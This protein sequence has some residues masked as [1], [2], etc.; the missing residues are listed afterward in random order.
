MRPQ[1]YKMSGRKGSVL[2]LVVLVVLISFIIGTG[3]L[4]L[5]TQSR[6]ASLH[7]TQD[8]MARSAADAG[9]EH[10]IQQIN[11]AVNNHT[12]SSKEKIKAKDNPLSS[13]SAYTVEG[14]YDIATEQ[15]DLV[16]VGTN[17][18]RVRTVHATI[19]LKGLFEYAILL[20]ETL[21]LKAGTTIDGYHSDD[22][23]VKDVGL[24]IATISTDPDQVILNMGATVNGEVLAG[25]GGD[26]DTVIKDL[27]ATTSGKFNLVEEPPFPQITAPLLTPMGSAISVAGTTSVITPADSGKYTDIRVEQIS[28]SEKVKGKTYTYTDYGTLEV[29]GG[30]VVLHVTGDIWI[31]QGCEILVKKDSSLTLYIDGNIV[32]GNGGGF[33]Y[34]GSPN[35]PSHVQ[36]YA[37]G[38]GEQNF[39]LKAKDHWSGVVYAPNADVTIFAKGDAYGSFVA[40]DLEFK[41]D[42]NMYYDGALRQVKVEDEGVRFAINRWHEQ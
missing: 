33:G 7:Q 9:L 35:E 24:Q 32:C 14:T 20:K 23:S 11:N 28:E 6:I 15:Y 2:V 39:D 34:T 18:D 31:G 27:G 42:G 16:S 19:G 37:T 3:L 12:W 25:V 38:S 22:P 17:G 13:G 10:A 36:L 41:A 1:K 4:A 21:T 29:S 8:M 40:N 5:G 30:D 26:V